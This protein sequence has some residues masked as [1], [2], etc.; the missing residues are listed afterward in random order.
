MSFQQ[1]CLRQK[2]HKECLHPADTIDSKAIFQDKGIHMKLSVLLLLVLSIS[3]CSNVSQEEL[4]AKIYK[5]TQ[6][7]MEYTY[8][9]DFRGKPYDV[10]C[11][12]KH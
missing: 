6:A 7:G 11:V 2:Y 1:K 3:A 10:M 12:R 4:D 9:K 5:C 8:L